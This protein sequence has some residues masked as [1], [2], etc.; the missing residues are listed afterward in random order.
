MV[1]PLA[2]TRYQR[3]PHRSAYDAAQAL[4]LGVAVHRPDQRHGLGVEELLEV[5]PALGQHALVFTA[6]GD[7]A[8]GATAS[9]SRPGS[10]PTAP[11]S[12]AAT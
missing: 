5:T 2:L 10:R 3:S 9:L 8:L 7:A 1:P 4:G 12:R 11:R 6:L